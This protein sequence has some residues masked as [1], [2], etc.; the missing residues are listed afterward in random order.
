M[1]KEQ[2]RQGSQMASY[3]EKVLDFF[4]KISLNNDV[5]K[6]LKEDVQWAI[7]VIS[8]NKLYGGGF[9]GFKIQEDK[10]E[11]KAWTD[12]INLRNLPINKIEQER[13]K[14]YEQAQTNL[15]DE[16]VRFTLKKSSEASQNNHQN[17]KKKMNDVSI[18][19]EQKG[20]L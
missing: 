17:A 16:K 2:K 8:A 5:P 10:P 6:H 11:V 7:D 1:I 20:L 14:Q 12:L 18:S 19:D 13:L 4:E 3:V 9:E 15:Q